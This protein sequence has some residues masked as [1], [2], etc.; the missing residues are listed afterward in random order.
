[1]QNF[2]RPLKKLLT[3]AGWRLLR[4]GKGDHEIWYNPETGQRVTLVTFLKSRHLANDILK[5]AGLP[6]AF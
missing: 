2:A 4:Q 6:K 3:D 5:D 1:M